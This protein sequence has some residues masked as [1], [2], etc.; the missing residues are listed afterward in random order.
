MVVDYEKEFDRMEQKIER[1]EYW[2]SQPNTS[3]SRS[4]LHGQY[5]SALKLAKVATDE[6]IK[7]GWED[8]AEIVHAIGVRLNPKWKPKK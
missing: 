8:C 2:A 1:V 7:K 3:E 6:R 4:H 5:H